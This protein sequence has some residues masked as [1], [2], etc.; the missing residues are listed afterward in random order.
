[1]ILRYDQA[2][3]GPAVVLLHARPADRTQWGQILRLLAAAGYRAI[4]PDLP[5]YGESPAAAGGPAAPWADVRDTLDALGVDRAVLAGNSLGAQ[6]ALEFAAT[7]P[8][9]VRGLC[10]MGYR[11]H[12]QTPSPRLTKALDEESQALARDDLDAAVASGLRAWLSP[13]AGPAE[14]ALFTRALRRNLTRRGEAV[15]AEAAPDPLADPAWA[16]KL[17]MPVRILHGADDLPDFAQG[18][19]KL[20]MA[21]H[22]PQITTVPDAGHLLPLDQPAAVATAILEL[23]AEASTA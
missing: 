15:P 21:L 19:Q 11:R 22:A 4:A 17:T 23:L 18:A 14:Q 1:M 9:R 5:G 10:L 12:G 13:A 2:G 3:T 20:Q 8:E 7:W 16:A 6:T